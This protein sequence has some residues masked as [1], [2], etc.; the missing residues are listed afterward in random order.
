M[1]EFT[2]ILLFRT[3]AIS[4]NVP[5]F[6]ILVKICVFIFLEKLFPHYRY[7]FICVLILR[8]VTDLNRGVGKH[9]ECHIKVSEFRNAFIANYYTKCGNVAFCAEEIF[10]EFTLEPIEAYVYLNLGPNYPNIMSSTDYI[11]SFDISVS[12]QKYIEFAN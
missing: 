2:S 4:L 1:K 6:L 11:L 12:F 7:I 3:P 9:R 8:V 5:R 10:T